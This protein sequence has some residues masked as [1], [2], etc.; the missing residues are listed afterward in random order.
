MFYLPASP[1]FQTSTVEFDHEKDIRTIQK[2]AHKMIMN[3]RYEPE[4]DPNIP[5]ALWA[6]YDE[7]KS[8]AFSLLG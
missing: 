1:G 7:V 3:K 6:R 8:K 2:L 5:D 4:L